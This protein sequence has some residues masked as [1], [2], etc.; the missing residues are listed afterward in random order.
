[1]YNKNVP[2][3][4]KDFLHEFRRDRKGLYPY[5]GV[6]GE[7]YVYASYDNGKEHPYEFLHDLRTDPFQLENLSE[8]DNY[9]EILNEI[10]E[11]CEVLENDFQF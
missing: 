11:R 6:R 1:L 5:I 2:D 3:W 8:I 7:R 9:K 4:R 10:R